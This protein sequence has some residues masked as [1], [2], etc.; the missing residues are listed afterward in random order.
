[1]MQDRNDLHEQLFLEQPI[2]DGVAEGLCADTAQTKPV[3]G[4]VCVV[5]DPVESGFDRVQTTLRLMRNLLVVV[6]LDI[7]QIPLSVRQKS[8]GV[9]HAVRRAR[10]RAFHSSRVM[11]SSGFASASAT[12]CSRIAH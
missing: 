10:R 3:D 6:R 9:A 8:D 11:W 7:A 12:R 5:G 2:P 1:M 4:L